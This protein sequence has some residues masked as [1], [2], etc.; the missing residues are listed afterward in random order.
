M[1]QSLDVCVGGGPTL[2]AR[3]TPGRRPDVMVIAHPHPLYGGSMDNNVVVAARDAA[4]ERGM[5][6]LRFNF[7]GVGRSG[8]SHD[9]GS[10]EV[11]DVR[12]AVSTAKVRAGAIRGHLTAYSFGAWVAAQAVADGL[13]VSSLCLISPPVDFTSFAGLLLPRVPCH[14]VVG[15]RDAYCSETS[16][17]AWLATQDAPAPVELIP[18]ADHFYFGYESALSGILDRFYLKALLGG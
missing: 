14:V 3:F 7:R 5:A 13:E 18:G 9:E 1:E 8:G 15:D 16:L 6:A 4:R 12:S 17:R 2:E 11:E 10:A